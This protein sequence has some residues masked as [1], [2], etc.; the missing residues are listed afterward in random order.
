MHPI[1][2]TLSSRVD[3]CVDKRSLSLMPMCQ[4]LSRHTFDKDSQ[5]ELKRVCERKALKNK[6]CV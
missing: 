5:A 4:I 2:I 1:I 6:S 3:E